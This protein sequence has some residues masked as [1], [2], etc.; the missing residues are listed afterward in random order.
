[1]SEIE[2][3]VT[4]KVLGSLEAQ[5]YLD[6]E[7]LLQSIDLGDIV[8]FALEYEDHYV[9]LERIGIEACKRYLSLKDSE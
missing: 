2:Y 8:D 9:L 4:D 1:M 5:L 3:T 7:D 6:V